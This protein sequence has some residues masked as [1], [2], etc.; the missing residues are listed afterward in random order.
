MLGC[1]GVHPDKRPEMLASSQAQWPLRRTPLHPPVCANP[2]RATTV[3]ADVRLQA[4]GAS[5][6][7]NTFAMVG[8][9]SY[10]AGSR[11]IADWRDAGARRAG[12]SGR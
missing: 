8:H 2:I 12:S 9:G 11:A 3:I 6:I 1:T 5:M 7:R 10:W 4:S